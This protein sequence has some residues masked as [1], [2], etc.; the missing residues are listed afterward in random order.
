MKNP[1][2]W[3]C[4]PYYFWRSVTYYFYIIQ[5][6]SHPGILFFSSGGCYYTKELISL[7]CA[8]Q[9]LLLGCNGPKSMNQYT[10][11][12]N[13]K[14]NNISI[15]IYQ[16]YLNP[17]N[18]LKGIWY[19]AISSALYHK[20]WFSKF[21]YKLNTSIMCLIKNTDLGLQCQLPPTQTF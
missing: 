11:S 18:I 7:S 15:I 19:P 14:S 21:D 5:E 10:R 17:K 4:Y 16:Y 1:Y 13:E 8:R 9:L 3:Y 2:T 12:T 20:K 6:V